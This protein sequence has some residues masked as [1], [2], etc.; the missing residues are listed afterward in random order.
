M[1]YYYFMCSV[2]VRGRVRV[3]IAA[4]ITIMSGAECLYDVIMCRK[5]HPIK[6]E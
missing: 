2:E 4:R 6:L 3:K 5:K 1:L